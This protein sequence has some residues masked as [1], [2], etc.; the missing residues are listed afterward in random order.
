[1]SVASLL[2]ASASAATAHDTGLLIARLVFGPMM[3]AHS[4]QKLFG[5]LGGYGL[6]GTGGFFEQL[7]FRPGRLFAAVASL[8]ELAG[9]LLIAFGLL[10]PIGPALVL[11]VMI[12]AAVTV[13]WGNGL[14]AGTNGIEVPVLYG[15]FSVMLA[16]TGPGLFSLD[17]VLGLERLWSPELAGVVLAVGVMGAIGNLLARRPAPAGSGVGVGAT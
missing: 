16:L 13:H 1:M 8:A 11:S 14:F 7:G 12:V 3:I 2:Q 9:G 10:G 5:W 17:A 15:A 4:T 6:A